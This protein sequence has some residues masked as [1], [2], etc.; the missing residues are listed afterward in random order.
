MIDWNKPIECTGY[1]GATRTE[2]EKLRVLPDGHAVLLYRA[3]GAL[4]SAVFDADTAVFRNVP[5]KPREF[6]INEYV[7]ADGARQAYAHDSEAE[8][9]A[10]STPSSPVSKRFHVRVI[11]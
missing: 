8:A 2:I 6:W 10:A 11:T 3:N 5:E 7:Y 4:V 9:D 1:C